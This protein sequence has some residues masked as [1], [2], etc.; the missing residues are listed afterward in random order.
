M[1]LINDAL[2]KAQLERNGKNAPAASNPDVSTAV[3]GGVAGG[4]RG[5]LVAL[6]FLVLIG[7]GGA[8][9]FSG[10]FD[11]AE[12]VAS[13][14]PK[15]AP[16][17]PSPAVP[18]TKP[19]VVAEA[20]PEPAAPVVPAVPAP[21]PAPAPAAP[22]PAPAPVEVAAPA[23]APAAPV[24]PKKDPA[25]E[26][27]VGLMNLSL[28]RKSTG[29]CVLDGSIYKVGELVKSDPLIKLEEVSDSGVVF[30]DAKGVRYEK[31]RN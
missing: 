9:Y 20:K 25:V 24:A 11:A 14:P 31:N 19:A 26:T 22:I 8:A 29:R 30:T 18:P 4:R 6:V 10:V 23:P 15:A 17:A 5:V 12:P 7:A 28:V 13:L 3:T 1:S 16:K 21:P 2:K 27:L